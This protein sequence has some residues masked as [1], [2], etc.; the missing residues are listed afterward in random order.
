[1]TIN[2]N[3]SIVVILFLGC[4]LV[5]ASKRGVVKSSIF[6]MNALGISS[7]RKPIIIKSLSASGSSTVFFDDLESSTG[8]W[9]TGGQWE[10]TTETSNSPTH[11]FHHAVGI[12]E[13]DTLL[14]PI[15]QLPE[16][17]AELEELHFSFAVLAEM[18]DA[19]S[20]DG[21]LEDYYR[22]WVKDMDNS[23]RGYSNEW[24]EYLDSPDIQITSSD[25]KLTFKLLYRLESKSSDLPYTDDS[26]CVLDGWDAANVQISKDSGSTWEVLEGTPEYVC[27]SCFGFQHNLNQCNVPGWTDKIDDWVDAEFDLS[28]FSGET[29]TVRFLFASDNGWGTADDTTHYRSGFYVDEVLV[30]NSSDTLL[31]D[32]ADDKVA[33]TP[34]GD[35]HWNTNEYN[36]Y[37][38]TKSWWA[39]AELS[40]PFYAVTYDYG[41]D[42]R[43]GTL[44]WEIYGPG[45]PFNEDTNVQLDLSQWAGDRVR[46]A[47]EFKSDD[48]HDGDTGNTSMGLYIDD[49]HVWKKSRAETASAPKGLTATTGDGTVELSWDAVPSGDFD[50]E[51]AYDDGSFEDGIFMTSGTGLSG[52]VFEMPFGSSVT[53]TTVKIF[54]AD[55]VSAVRVYGYEVRGGEPDEEPI[56]D[57]TM[58]RSLDVWHEIDLDWEFEGDFLIAQ[59]IDTLLHAGLDF[60]AV[61]SRHSWTKLGNGP[62]QRWQTIAENNDLPDGEWGIRVVVIANGAEVA[63]N[64][65]RHKPGETFTEPLPDGTFLTKTSF[66]DSLVLVA[67]DYT[68]AVTSVYYPGLTNELE[69]GFSSQVTVEPILDTVREIVY[70]DGTSETGASALG[71]NGWYAVRFSSNIFPITLTTLKYHAKEEGGLTYLAIFDDDGNG[72]MPGNQIGA[73][74]IFPTVTQGWNIKDVSGAGLTI[75]EGQFYVAWGETADSPPLSIDTDSDVMDRSYFYTESDGWGNISDLG[76]EGN[77]LIRT[78]VDI[79]SAGELTDITPPTVDITNPTTDSQMIVGEIYKITWIA[80]DNIWITDLDLGYTIDG[81]QNWL[82]IE[83]QMENDGEYEWVVPNSPSDQL[84]IE[85]IAGDAAGLSDTS[86]VMGLSIIVAYPTIKLYSPDEDQLTWRDSEIQ[87]QFSK[88]LDPASIISENIQI[89]SGHSPEVEL[90]Y[91]ESTQTLILTSLPSYASKDTVSISLKSSAITDLFGYQLDGNGDGTPGDDFELVYHTSLLA[92]FDNSKDLDAVDLAMFVQ[93]WE[94]KDY[95][96]ELGPVSGLA[97]HFVSALDFVYD[98]E[99][100]M[101]FAMSWNW[102]STTNNFNFINLTSFGLPITLQSNSSSIGVQLPE[103]VLAYQVQVKYPVGSLI[104]HNPSKENDLT[105]VQNDQPTGVFTMLVKKGNEQSLVLP[106]TAQGRGADIRVSFRA[107]G[108]DGQIISQGT[109]IA[110]VQGIPQEYT[111]HQNYP[112]PFNPTTTIL[113]DVPQDSKVTLFIYDLLGRQV[114][115]LVNQDISAGFHDA[116]WDAT[117]DMGR[118][119]SGGL[120]IYRINAGGYSKTMKMVLLK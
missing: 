19:A 25:Y 20:P 35:S 29:V 49:L 91:S 90:T 76:Y 84:G 64:V 120:Y 8:D 70:D 62:W 61:P 39:G 59:E 92:D 101:A 107:V 32:N 102:Y 73:T 27:S 96:Y 117:D 71:E 55:A 108:R 79:K 16:I 44:G 42:G 89:S 95:F 75:T 52:N 50:G 53:V 48:N 86:R 66:T 78:V 46:V 63:Y 51:V 105:L 106:V 116:I 115:T 109:E 77:L 9:I 80:E 38:G 22:L 113:Y 31:Y 10:I 43:P 97:P 110:H 23:I 118:P 56:Y 45:S 74:L 18:I 30:S 111:L 37:D 60:D 5:G 24:V 3:R 103:G 1:M 2:F 99:D 14:S 114:R 100:L 57:T 65:Y 81:G 85:L 112:N 83:T 4:F 40:A 68:Y 7:E 12:D 98:I 33:L 36:G 104:I 15:I 94:Q 21:N 11:S 93:G 47:W 72:G 119:V 69:S 26:G 28:S 87:I 41:A 6:Q 13:N 88:P 82:N 17:D 58:S 67:V 34:V 54:G